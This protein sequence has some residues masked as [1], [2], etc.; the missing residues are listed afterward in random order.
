V[1]Y[2]Q[3]YWTFFQIGLFSI[4]GGYASLP[5]IQDQVV[6]RNGWLTIEEFIDVVTVSQMTPGPIAINAATFIGVQLGG[7]LGALVAT[8]GSVTPSLLIVLTIAYFYFKH[9]DLF[10]IK[11]LLRGI[12]PVVVA[13]IASAMMSILL[14][15]LFSSDVDSW[16]SIELSTLDWKSLLLFLVSFLVVL[17]W[18]VDPIHLIL[19]SGFVGF[20]L[21]YVF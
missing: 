14:L 5:I 1:L 11:G 16:F 20:I 18:K 9:Q 3:L 19:T 6:N 4:G 2:F 17:K 15:A 10:L 13:L 8:L 12:R 7:F 21:Y